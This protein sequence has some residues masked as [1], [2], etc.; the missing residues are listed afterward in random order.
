MHIAANSANHKVSA[1][2]II[3]ISHELKIVCDYCILD[4]ERG[5]ISVFMLW[6]L[7]AYTLHLDTFS[8]FSNGLKSK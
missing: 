2:M 4:Q 8:S 1:F 5:K 3:I 6:L 7:R